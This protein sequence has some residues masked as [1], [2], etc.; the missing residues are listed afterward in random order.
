[1]SQNKNKNRVETKYEKLC[2]NFGELRWR[3]QLLRCYSFCTASEY[4]FQFDKSIVLIFEASLKLLC[5]FVLSGILG[6]QKPYK[7][8][9]CQ[10]RR[11]PSSQIE[12]TEW[13]A[14]SWKL[15]F[16]FLITEKLQLVCGHATAFVCP[17]MS[18]ERTSPDAEKIPRARLTW[19]RID[20]ISGNKLHSMAFRFDCKLLSHCGMANGERSAYTLVI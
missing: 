13:N 14:S 7:L 2:L 19:R 16:Y 1:M 4:V 18:A 10:R 20:I 8:K 5:P 12:L 15:I 3:R 9:N 17:S 11:A 6:S